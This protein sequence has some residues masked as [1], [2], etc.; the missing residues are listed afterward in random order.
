[1]LDQGYGIMPNVVLFDKDLSSTSKLVFVYI[2]SLCAQQ[3]YCWASNEHIA[4][5]FGI[6]TSAVSRAIKQLSAYL[7]IENPKNERRV[8]RLGINAQPVTQKRRSSLGKNASHN[9][10]KNNTSI[11]GKLRYKTPAAL[12]MPDL[13]GY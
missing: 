3:G 10:I 7:D 4:S 6:S 1:M 11:I 12:G 5:K 2:S 13:G 8:I 9:S